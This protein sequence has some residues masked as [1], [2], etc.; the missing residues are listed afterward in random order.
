M[1]TGRKGRKHHGMSKTPAHRSWCSMR[2]RCYNKAHPSYPRYGGRGISICDRWDD[3]HAFLEDMGDRPS[4]LHSIDR[5]D[6]NGNYEPGNCRWAT[7]Y[8]QANNRTCNRHMRIGGELI[9]HKEAA[10][11]LGVGYQALRKATAKP[12]FDVDSYLRKRPAKITATM[13]SEIRRLVLAGEKSPAIAAVVGCSKEKVLQIKN[14]KDS[15]GNHLDYDRKY[16]IT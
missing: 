16:G 12:G 15:L 11:K 14:N 3:F 6:P 5:I 9:P 1:I 2:D 8:E 10:E 4:E 7:A 13:V